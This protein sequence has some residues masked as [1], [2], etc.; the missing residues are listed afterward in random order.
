VEVW[1]NKEEVGTQMEE[2]NIRDILHILVGM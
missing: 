1:E 2:A